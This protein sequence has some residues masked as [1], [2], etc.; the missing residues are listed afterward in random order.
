MCEKRKATLSNTSNLILFHMTSHLHD[1][2]PTARLE[3][4]KARASLLKQIRQFFETRDVL[5]VDTPLL[6]HGTVTDVHL[7]AFSSSFSESH[8]GK[9]EDLYLQTSPE[10]AMKR[11]LCAGYGDIYQICKAF[12]HEAAGRFHNPE[13]TMLEWYRLGFT[14]RELMMEMDALL[15]LTLNTKPAQQLSY[16]AVFLQQLGIDPLTASVTE[17]QAVATAHN[18]DMPSGLPNDTDTLLQLLFSLL[19]E[20]VIGAEAPC[21]VYG[22][23]VSQAALARV[24]ST[25]KRTADRFE[26]YF[27]GVE[28]ANGFY[29]LADS[30]EQRHRFIRD[31]DS[32]RELGLP[33]L[34]VDEHFLSALDAGL[35]DCAG[36]AMGLDRLLMLKLD[37]E[38][39]KDVIPFPIPRA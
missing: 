20:P 35:P 33:E 32:R 12:R 8:T 23:P 27:K 4:L 26:V 9:V 36:V 16:Q 11:L 25:D 6:C 3:N 21:F 39:I 19:I 31:N 5:E 10:Y 15:Q 28:L 30:D 18:I 14:H 29:E 34:P 17:L 1:W 37:A 38:H 13:F 22:F 7:S 2:Q 24:N